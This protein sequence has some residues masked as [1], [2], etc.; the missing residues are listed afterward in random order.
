MTFSIVLTADSSRVA[1]VIA[2][3]RVKVA[4]STRP[5]P[6][7]SRTPTRSMCCRAC[8]AAVLLKSSVAGLVAC[9]AAADKAPDAGYLS[10][11][12]RRRPGRHSG[13]VAA[14][15]DAGETAAAFA[16]STSHARNRPA[17]MNCGRQS[18]RFAARGGCADRACVSTAS[19]FAKTQRQSD[20]SR[21]HGQRRVRPVS[22]GPAGSIGR[23]RVSA[24]ARVREQHVTA[25]RIGRLRA[26][27]RGRAPCQLL[28]ISRRRRDAGGADAAENR[29]SLSRAAAAPNEQARPAGR[30]WP[31]RA[32]N[33]PT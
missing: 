7:D 32:R 21:G 26:D 16:G 4:K 17:P 1:V 6:C 12:Q 19:P 33:R 13:Q 3:S 27:R 18:R 5:L 29:S 8:A 15:A 14:Y 22:R 24:N 31:T 23:A 11:W 28:A 9:S 20:R 2:S 10:H 25:P 30:A